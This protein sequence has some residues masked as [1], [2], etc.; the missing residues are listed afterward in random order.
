VNLKRTVVDLAQDDL[1]PYPFLYLTGLDEFGFD[2][3]QVSVL[4]RYLDQGGVLLINNGL[5]LGTFDAA[6]RQL[7]PTLL[8]GVSLRRIESNH[9]LYTSLFDVTRVRYSPSLAKSKPELDQQP[10]LLGAYV[11]GELR[12]I[13]SPYDLE[14]GWLDVYY[15][16]MRGYQ[17][18]SSQRLGINTVMY[19]MT[20]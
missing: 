8:P 1:T 13:Y 14:A 10:Y 11:N 3:G 16:L 18:L 15:P 2:A 12:V 6:V 5:G 7:L 4:R 9:D 19:L 20:H 17:A